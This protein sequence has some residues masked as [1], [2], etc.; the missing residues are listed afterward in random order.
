MSPAPRL[1]TLLAP[2]LAVPVILAGCTSATG[3]ATLPT[4]SASTPSF[5]QIPDRELVAVYDEPFD[6]N[7]GDWLEPD[8]DANSIAGGE[9]AI[10][11]G[12]GNSH[13]VMGNVPLALMPLYEVQTNIDVHGSGLGEVAIY[14]RLDHGFTGFYKAALSANGVR[15]SKGVPEDDASIDMFQ[16]TTPVLSPE[17]DAVFS[18]GCFAED[19]GFHVEAFVDDTLV[20]QAIDAADPPEGGDV[21][22]A[23]SNLPAGD[24]D[25]DYLIALRSLLL[26]TRA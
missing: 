26:E 23:W 8:W 18:V 19:D 6:D 5:V 7:S 10:V 9:Y 4:P 15:I 22:I 20:G 13:R 24:W 12:A 16:S 2:L 14:C 3:P 17:V 21:R 1:C 11:E 25:G